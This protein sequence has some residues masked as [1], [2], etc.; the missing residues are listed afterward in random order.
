MT[1]K[2]DTAASPKP[3]GTIMDVEHVV[4]L[5]QENRSFDHYFGTLR[6]VRGFGDRFPIPVPAASGEERSVWFQRNDRPGADPALV[7]PF[8]LNTEQNFAQMRVA[9]TPHTW[10]DAQFAWN[11]GSID[12]WPTHKHNH[13][14]GYFT[15]AD[16]PFQFALADAFTVCD[17]PLFGPGGHQSEP[18]ICM[19][20]HHRSV[21]AGPRPG[22]RQQLRTCR[23]R[24]RRRLYLEH[25][26][27][28]PAGGRRALAGVPGHQR[29]LHR[30][31]AG[32]LYN[33][34]RGA[35]RRARR[36]SGPARARH[37]YAHALAAARRR[38]GRYAGASVVHRR[39][40]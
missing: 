21:R 30:Q 18:R 13:A 15:Q 11:N 7:C 4:I 24:P 20:R 3:T 23:L 16:I 8:H 19:D 14:M 32:R 39:H 22:H 25:L 17:V 34:S 31:S 1:S 2:N 40:R 29:Q 36:R 33:F 28:A 27:R 9:G 35:G 5:M 12:A 38:H 37:E 10:P 26:L 6:G